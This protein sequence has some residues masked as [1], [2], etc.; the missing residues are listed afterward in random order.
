MNKNRKMTY[1]SIEKGMPR[2]PGC[3][4]WHS[5]KYGP[6]GGQGLFE[7]TLERINSIWERNK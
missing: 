5:L 2:K 1:F 7:E 6:V 4:K 3:Q